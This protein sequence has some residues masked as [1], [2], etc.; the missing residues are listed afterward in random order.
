MEL[1]D[2]LDAFSSFSTQMRKEMENALKTE[3]T[4]SESLHKQMLQTA[5]RAEEEIKAAQSMIQAKDKEAKAIAERFNQLQAHLKAK[6][7][8]VEHYKKVI[9]QLQ[10]AMKNAAQLQSRVRDLESQLHE[11]TKDRARLERIEA[12]IDQVAKNESF[13]KLEQSIIEATR[14]INQ[15]E[16]LSRNVAGQHGEMLQN[17]INELKRLHSESVQG[18][19]K[20][21]MSTAQMLLQMNSGFKMIEKQVQALQQTFAQNGGMNAN[22]PVLQALIQQLPNQLQNQFQAQAQAQMQAIQAHLQANAMVSA[23]TNQTSN[24]KT[25]TRETSP[26]NDRELARL[27]RENQALR[28]SF[29]KATE[30]VMALKKDFASLQESSLVEIDRLREREQTL[31]EHVGELFGEPGTGTA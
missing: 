16:T 3:K 13:T 26:E 27:K 14:T 12:K 1:L 8:E 22:D 6:N 24:E 2:Q 30:E 15:L 11:A 19:N 21:E 17:S 10:A 29:Q 25:Q 28:A 7:A 31:R 20:G 5:M 18:R 4:R 9:L 23:R